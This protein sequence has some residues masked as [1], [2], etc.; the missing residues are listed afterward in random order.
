MLLWKGWCQ[1][2]VETKFDFSLS[3]M[4]DCW[5]TTE[6]LGRS[7]SGWMV[8]TWAPAFWGQ[9]RISLFR[10]FLELYLW[11]L[12]PTWVHPCSDFSWCTLMYQKPNSLLW[13]SQS[14]TRSLPLFWL[15]IFF[16]QK[17][18][19]E[20]TG[21]CTFFILP[22]KKITCMKASTFCFTTSSHR[23][24]CLLE[25]GGAYSPAITKAPQ[26]DAREIS[27]LFTCTGL[28]PEVSIQLSSLC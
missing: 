24:G 9:V 2:V 18:S 27:S 11:W 19:S 3:A 26:G 28:N 20:N 6:E 7:G 13:A 1:N 14:S 21:D 25:Q 5:E 8:C 17:M 4:H 15:K 23:F 22:K 12:G 16:E 10:S